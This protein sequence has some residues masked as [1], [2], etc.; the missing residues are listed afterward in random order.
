MS[1]SI[2]LRVDS[3][4]SL[5]APFDFISLRLGRSS[6]YHRRVAASANLSAASRSFPNQRPLQASRMD[7]AGWGRYPR[8]HSTVFRPEKISELAEVISRSTRSAARR[9]Q[10]PMATRR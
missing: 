6:C 5:R 2:A 7:I 4:P 8:S 3:S 10:G 1:L 9:L